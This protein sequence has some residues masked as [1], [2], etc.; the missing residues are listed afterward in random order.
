[1]RPSLQ[2]FWGKGSAANRGTPPEDGGLSDVL[3]VYDTATLLTSIGAE[4]ALQPSFN[5]MIANISAREN[6]AGYAVTVLTSYYSFLSADLSKYAHIWDI[7]FATDTPNSVS[8]KYLSYL[9]TG[10]A[11]FLL[12]ENSGFNIRNQGICNIVSVAGGGTIT[13]STQEPTSVLTTI[14]EPEFLLKNNNNIVTFYAPG[15]FRVIG[16]GTPMMSGFPTAQMPAVMWKTESLVNAPK[17]AIVSVLDI[18]FLSS[19]IQ[20]N[21]IDNIAICLNKK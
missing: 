15:D 10:G 11:V 2:G 21:F 4:E 6:T 20:P 9:Q 1:M 14:L 18:N 3:I 7:P 13:V 17:G 12:G 8:L 5:S 16:T 19:H